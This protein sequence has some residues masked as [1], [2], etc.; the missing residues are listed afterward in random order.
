MIQS[1]YCAPAGRLE[2]KH[3][4]EQQA[5][6]QAAFIT[7][8]LHAVPDMMLI[9]NHQR[10]IIAVNNPLLFALGM[11]DQSELLGMRLGE[12]I[13][14]IHSSSGTDGCG[15]S[16]QCAACVA[17]L[18]VFASQK[19]GMQANGECRLVI[20]HNGGTVLDLEATATPFDVAGMSFTIVAL[21]DIGSV[22]R[23][24]VLERTFFH[25]ILNTVGGIRGLAKLL[26][27]KSRLMP[28]MESEYK[29]LLVELSDGLAEEINQQRRLLA[30]ERGEYI[31]DLKETDLNEML[32]EV[33]NLYGNHIHAHNR[34][35]RLDAALPCSLTTD[36]P[37]LRRIVGNMVLNALEATPAG[38]T[39]SVSHIVDNE[40]ICIMV[41]N[42]GE[43][44]KYVQSSIFRKTFSTK[45]M[46]ERGIG[47][48]SMKLFG[49]RYLKG[50]VG[51]RSRDGETMFFIKFPRN[52]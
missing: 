20:S 26:L 47:T 37:L 15:T 36:R 35:V 8:V 28:E 27:D 16:K 52:A 23:R 1:T 43:I 34:S 29:E 5:A 38:G 13:S 22:E 7:A 2:L 33:C 44:P 39:V 31:P 19:S 42:P 40:S 49:E 32:Q 4:E 11:T 9:L 51:F 6:V 45:N 46:A 14:C 12:A 48:Y 41:R 3:L 21:R 24:Q 25:D 30:A 17:A 18:T 10:Q 50:T